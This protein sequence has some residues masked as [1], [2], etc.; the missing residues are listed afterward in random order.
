MKKYLS[1]GLVLVSLCILSGCQS[2]IVQQLTGGNTSS[3]TTSS[4]RVEMS[5]STTSS[6]S[7]ESSSSTGSETS[8]SSTSSSTTSS[9]QQ[10]TVTSSAEKDYESLYAETLTK[11]AEDPERTVT[12]YA[13]YD[14][15]GNGTK[16]LFTG[17]QNSTGAMYGAAVYYLN[18]SVSTYL[19][20]SEV[21][22]VG[23]YRASFTIN[24][25]R[26]VTQYEWTSFRGEGIKKTY[27]LAAD[28]SSAI[29]VQ[30]KEIIMGS[31]EQQAEADPN[32]L[33]LSILN[34][35]VLGY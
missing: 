18:Q 25:D 22:P 35:Q 16:E 24:S 8:T 29:L 3:S 15:D 6:T 14:I 17:G 11:V 33:D 19:A 28:D 26:T 5:S 30:E 1:F 34:W 23:G 4:S 27:Q 7:L 13:F 20:H 2:A 32:P 31:A 9:S 10:E 21:A 12:H